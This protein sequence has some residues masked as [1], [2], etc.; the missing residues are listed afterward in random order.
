MNWRRIGEPEEESEE[1]R[2]P[3]LTTIEFWR[4][5][6]SG[7]KKVGV[8]GRAP[9][10][11]EDDREDCRGFSGENARRI[12][13]SGSRTIGVERGREEDED[14]KEGREE[15][16]ILSKPLLSG[17]SDP[18]VQV[19]PERDHGTREG[20]PPDRAERMGEN[21]VGSRP[22]VWGKEEEHCTEEAPAR[23]EEVNP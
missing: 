7:L 4:S 20:Q 13:M 2:N 12:A 21:Q 23:T 6:R 8:F 14:V 16:K 1:S 15:E 11:G 10:R 19:P 5:I 9:N 17:V 22:I 18:L 3:T